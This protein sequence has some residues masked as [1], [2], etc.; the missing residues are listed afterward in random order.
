MFRNIG[1]KTFEIVQLFPKPL[2]RAFG[3]AAID[4]RQ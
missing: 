3:V 1:G 2:V 4:I